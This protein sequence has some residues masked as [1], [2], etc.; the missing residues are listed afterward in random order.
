[1]EGSVVSQTSMGSRLWDHALGPDFH[2]G[3]I[4]THDDVNEAPDGSVSDEAAFKLVSL[5]DLLDND[6]FQEV[7]TAWDPRA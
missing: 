2:K 5:A 6:L 4:V 3:L 1:M 7:D